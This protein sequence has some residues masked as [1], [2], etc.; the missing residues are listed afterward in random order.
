MISDGL[1]PLSSGS[2]LGARRLSARAGAQLPALMYSQLHTAE[3]HVHPPQCMGD[4]HTVP[5]PP[6]S[7]R[8]DRERHRAERQA[9][10]VASPNPRMRFANSPL[11]PH[12]QSHSLRLRQRSLRC[13]PAHRPLVQPAGV[14]QPNE[15]L[16]SIFTLCPATPE[17]GREG[18]RANHIHGAG[19]CAATVLH[20]K[21]HAA[22]TLLNQNPE[23]MW[24][25]DWRP[26]QPCRARTCHAMRVHPLR[27]AALP[28]HFHTRPRA[29]LSPT[30]GNQSPRARTADVVRMHPRDLQHA[31]PVHAGQG[32]ALAH[33]HA[34]CLATRPVE[35]QRSVLN[36][37][38]EP[39]STDVTTRSVRHAPSGSPCSCPCS[40]EGSV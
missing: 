1:C 5:P 36:T 13:E 19:P 22:H 40:I 25:E 17:L 18:L 8:S 14:R 6:A 21:H 28:R 26:A 33:V 2:C 32:S 35:K 38:A 16:A 3:R 12:P 9:S 24:E 10:G 27:I 15:A 31:I 29:D 30:L 11:V 7:R 4:A 37:A 39:P 20:A 34:G 23:L